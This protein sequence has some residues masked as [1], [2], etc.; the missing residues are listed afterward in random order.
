MSS[1]KLTKRENELIELYGLGPAP[2]PGTLFFSGYDPF[3]SQYLPDDPYGRDDLAHARLRYWTLK[4]QRQDCKAAAPDAESPSKPITG[5]AVIAVE[6]KNRGGKTLSIG[7]A[8]YHEIIQI[9]H[10]P[11]GLPERDELMRRLIKKFPGASE[12]NL[13]S[14]LADVYNSLRTS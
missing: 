12:S 13:R 10:T 1:Q 2:Q 4:R 6:Q 9:A 8:I 7:K 14:V 11:D 5:G 3:E